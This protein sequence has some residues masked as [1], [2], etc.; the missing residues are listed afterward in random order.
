[1]LYGCMVGPDYERPPRRLPR[2]SRRR[3]TGRSRSRAT[4]L[5]RGNWWEAFH[6]PD[7]NA[8]EEQVD[9]SNQTIQAAEARVR[10]ASAATQAARSALFPVVNGNAAALRSSR[11][12]GTTAA[13]MTTIRHDHVRRRRSTVT[14]WRSTRAGKS[15]SGA[16]S[17]AES[18]PVRAR[19]R[20][21]SR[22]WPAPGSPRKPCWPRITCCCAWRMRRS[23]CCARP[24]PNYERSLQLTRN[25]YAAG[26]A[27]RGDV[28]QAEA[29]LKSTQAQ[30]YD[31]Q[32]VRA[33][34]EHAIARTDRQA[35]VR[36]DGRGEAPGR[37]VS[38]H[39]RRAALC[40]ARAPP[41]HRRSRAPHRQRQRA[42]RR[43]AGGVLPGAYPVGHGRISR[44][45]SSAT[46]YR[47]LP[48]T[49]RSAPRWRKPIFDAGLR[50]A[51]K[52]QAIATYDETVA[53]Y[54]STVLGGVPGRR[55]QSGGAGVAGAG[56]DCAG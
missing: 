8:L 15:T 4:T 48:A 5:P 32:I 50:S 3:Q 31:A 52:A 29:Q 43:C 24:S 34:L 55:G 7:L 56:G 18:R 42:D 47:C 30:V 45:R 38:G 17:V 12:A 25:Q 9:I 10:E 53:N 51:Q 11:V 41:R 13:T 40:V 22:I 27:G 49:G 46:C 23:H 37:G 1:M 54:R 26:I 16:A 44:V 14:T 19:R 28:V 33:Q 20:P 2:R 35:A 39:S 21:R 6:D 36:I